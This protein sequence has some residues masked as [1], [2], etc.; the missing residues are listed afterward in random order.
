MASEAV[1]RGA[2]EGAGGAVVGAGVGVDVDPTHKQMC[3]V[4][5]LD[6]H[7]A[8]RSPTTQRGLEGGP[9]DLW[10]PPLGCI[11]II[12]IYIYADLT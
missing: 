1:E 7:E 3:V 11:Y 12:Y 10:P 2:L 4:G 9:G 5:G 6:P 8:L